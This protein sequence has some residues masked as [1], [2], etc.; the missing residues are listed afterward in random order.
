M[1]YCISMSY[2]F[3]G[4]HNAI[5]TVLYKYLCIP[6]NYKEQMT[7]QSESHCKKIIKPQIYLYYTAK[8]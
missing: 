4:T 1:K 7:Q 2:F 3:P 5:N 8:D 6:G